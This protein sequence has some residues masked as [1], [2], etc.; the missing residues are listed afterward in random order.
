MN[1][2]N[3]N[4]TCVETAN[5]D[6]GSI[7]QIGWVRVRNGRITGGRSTLVNPEEYFHPVNTSIHGI[8][9]WEVRDAPT[10][11]RLAERLR[12]DLAGSPLVSH[13]RF[14]RGALDRAMDKYGLPALEVEWLDSARIARRAWPDRYGTRGWNLA[15]LARDLGITFSHHDALEDARA[16]ALVVLQACRHTGQDIDHW[17]EERN[18]IGR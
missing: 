16:A 13:T 10:L 9:Q 8:D 3:F 7:C 12:R 17:L 4:A 6:H 14:D 2:L 15:N 18:N 1:N 5:P 11:Y